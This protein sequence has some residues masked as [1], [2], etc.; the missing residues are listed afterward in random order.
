[1]RQAGLGKHV[2]KHKTKEQNKNVINIDA[3]TMHIFTPLLIVGFSGLCRSAGNQVQAD[4]QIT[5]AGCSSHK[6]TKNSGICETTKGVQQYSGYISV[7]DM[8]IWFW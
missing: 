7:E 3:F 1:M 8:N 5:A 6:I 4:G 2:S